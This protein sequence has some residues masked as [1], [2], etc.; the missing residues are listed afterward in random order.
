MDETNSASA[1]RNPTTREILSGLAVVLVV[2]AIMVSRDGRIAT[3]Q[4]AFDDLAGTSASAQAECADG[5][6]GP[7]RCRTANDRESRSCVDPESD[8]RPDAR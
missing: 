5:E 4:A 6:S 7:N 2:A 1:S 8:A 3:T